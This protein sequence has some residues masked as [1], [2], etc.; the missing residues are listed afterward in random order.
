MIKNN[1]WKA[2]ISSAILI[3]P[4]I[5]GLIL[6][7]KLPDT[8]VTHWN[9]KG[10]PDGYSSKAFTVLFYPLLM[11]FFHWLCLLG[12]MLDKKNKGQNQKMIGLVFWICPVASIFMMS[13]TYAHALG[14]EFDIVKKIIPLF[15]IMFI[16]LGNYLPKTKQNYTIGLKFPWT[17]DDEAT[18]NAS[19]RF[20]GKLWVIGG[21]L[22]LPCMFLP[23]LATAIVFTVLLFAMIIIP[24]V[25][26]Y[27]Y[28]KKHSKK[29]VQ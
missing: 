5:A 12:S 7:N 9:F 4:I 29:D 26:S 6:W 17:L 10:E 11:I 13:A 19:H 21:I 14:A 8:L 28:Y 27:V 15:S 24:I 20:C 18:W 25:Y 3:L 1:K 16:A 23:P 22:I 2:I